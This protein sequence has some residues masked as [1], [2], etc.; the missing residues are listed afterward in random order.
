M[1]IQT[2]YWPYNNRAI[3]KNHALAYRLFIILLQKKKIPVEITTTCDN[4][5]SR[6]KSPTPINMQPQA[7]NAAPLSTT[8]DNYNKTQ[9][10]MLPGYW[11]PDANEEFMSGPQ[12]EKCHEACKLE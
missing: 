2:R 6:P 10:N 1:Y 3:Q 12:L 11:D 4:F 7:E 9:I 8:I 5:N